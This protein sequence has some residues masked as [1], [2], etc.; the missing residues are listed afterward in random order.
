MKRVHELP[1]EPCLDV[2]LI[3]ANG[4]IEKLER[5]RGPVREVLDRLGPMCSEFASAAEIDAMLAVHG[6]LAEGNLEQFEL[7]A[8]TSLGRSGGTFM[9]LK[10]R[11]AQY[12]GE[13]RVSA[14]LHLAPP[15]QRGAIVTGLV[16]PARATLWCIGQR[17]I[18]HGVTPGDLLDRYRMAATR[19]AGTL[20]FTGADGTH[21]VVRL[22]RRR[23]GSASA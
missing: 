21:L 4:E 6:R 14:Q 17:T 2:Y 12:P 22:R 3:F 1:A 18:L 20:E 7:I 5:V 10:G 8:P 19:R 15:S 23:F 16:G 9:V 11:W 13:P